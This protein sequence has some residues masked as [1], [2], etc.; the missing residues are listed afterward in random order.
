MKISG[1]LYFAPGIKFSDL[2]LSGL[3][4]SGL[5]LAD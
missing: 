4:L 1:I 5:K 3:D 2:D